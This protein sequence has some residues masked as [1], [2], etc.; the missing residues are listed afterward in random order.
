MQKRKCTA[1]VLAAGSGSRMNGQVAKQFLEFRGKPL[2]F[3]ALNTME[4]SKVI[5]DCILV[6]QEDKIEWVRQEIVEKFGFKKVSKIIAGGKERYDS[7]RNAVKILS[8]D[9]YI[10]IHDGARTLVSE[11]ILLRGLEA[12]EAYGACVAAVPVKDTIK[13]ADREQFAVCTPDRNT[14]WTIQ[15]PQIFRGDIVRQA[16]A[17]LP[18]DA[19]VTDDAGVVEQYGGQKVKLFLG[20]YTNIKVTTPDDLL[21]MEV[22]LSQKSR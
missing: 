21:L 17:A 19:A 14:L 3:Y 10:F 2:I 11:E 15:T 16:Y 12:V 5:D 7:V 4:Q 8:D 13:I 18:E 1:V 20:E 6:T 22:F 9:E